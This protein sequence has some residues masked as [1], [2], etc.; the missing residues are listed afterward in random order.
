LIGD[1]KRD[2]RTIDVEKPQ[3]KSIMKYARAVWS[4]PLAKAIAPG[5][6]YAPVALYVTLTGGKRKTMEKNRTKEALTY[7]VVLKIISLRP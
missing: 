7:G 4:P 6:Q 3:F 2:V 1:F 5:Y